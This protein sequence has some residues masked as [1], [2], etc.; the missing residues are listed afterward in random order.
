MNVFSKIND[1]YI[2][3][4]KINLIL[5]NMYITIMNIWI[6]LKHTFGYLLFQK[7]IFDIFN[8]SILQLKKR[9]ANFWK[10]GYLNVSTRKNH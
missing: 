4:N 5:K 10:L 2:Q 8:S 1:L 7:V 3:L 9:K 6:V